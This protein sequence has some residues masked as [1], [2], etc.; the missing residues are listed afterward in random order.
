MPDFSGIADTY[1]Q[2]IM[3]VKAIAV[4]FVAL[5]LFYNFGDDDCLSSLLLMFYTFSL[6]IVKYSL[7]FLMILD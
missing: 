4:S 1:T 3:R 7:G 5:A 2:I 6:W